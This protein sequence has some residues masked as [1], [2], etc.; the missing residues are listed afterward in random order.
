MVQQSGGRQTRRGAGQD[1]GKRITMLTAFEEDLAEKERT[2]KEL[3]DKLMKGYDRDQSGFLDKQEMVRMLKDYA[4]EIYY[5]KEL[6]S[7]DDVK[8]LISVADRD[9]G[10]GKDGVLDRTEVL[11]ACY[12]WGD[13]IQKKSIM[14]QLVKNHD[15]DADELIDKVELASILFEIGDG[16]IVPEDALDWI[17]EEADLDKSG[18]LNLMELARATCAFEL[19][20]RGR[21]RKS[22]LV[23]GVKVPEN[24][25]A[26]TSKRLKNAAG[27]M[28]CAMM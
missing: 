19:W 28:M 13:F 20:K 15:Q 5:Q 9:D 27:S 22:K 11:D 10:N 1:I 16:M 25:R 4:Q 6:P 12:A 18:V 17:F 2:R 8:F 21:A 14:A 7:E 3:A 26:R 24:L 23:V